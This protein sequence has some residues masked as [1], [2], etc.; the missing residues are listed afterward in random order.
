MQRRVLEEEVHYQTAVDRGVDRVSCAYDFFKRGLVCYHDEGACLVLRH[1]AACF[2]YVVDSFADAYVRALPVLA[3]E[4]VEDGLALRA[5]HVSA[6]E[7][8]EELPYLRLEDDD[9]GDESDVKHGLHDVGHE[10]HVECRY[11]DPD[12]IK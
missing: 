6:S 1:P 11:D 3:E 9:D 10:P 8:H 5:V 4:L 2:R 7:P 12:H